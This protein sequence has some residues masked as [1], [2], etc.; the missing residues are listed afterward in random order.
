MTSLVMPLPVR[1]SFLA[2]VE[3]RFFVPAYSSPWARAWIAT[4]DALS[5]PFQ[6]RGRARRTTARTDEGTIEV[7]EMG[8]GKHTGALLHQLLGDHAERADEGAVSLSPAALR[9]VEGDL[10]LAEIHRSMAPRFRRAGWIVVPSEVRWRGDLTR[11][12][13]ATPSLKSDLGKVRKYGYVLEH[14]SSAV[15]WE[16]FYDGMLLPQ[17]RAR[18]GAGAWIPSET[19]RRELTGRG[20][21]HFIRRD[22]VRVAGICSVRTGPTLWLPVMGLC[23]GNPG[24]LREGAYA[25]VFA[26]LFAW[27]RD[28]GCTR[29]DAGRTSAF[30]LDGIQR[31]KRKWGLEPVADPLAHLIAVRVGPSARPAFARQPVLIETDRGIDTYPEAE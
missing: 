22:G 11:R 28:Q 7:V 19:L 21:L 16:E 14:A 10:V 30:T 12:P 3:E 4:H 26:L 17:A 31:F 9:L 23:Q 13:R 18:F 8:R 29:V 27:A 20:A 24:L 25:A 1:R 5:L 2:T 6:L 15:D